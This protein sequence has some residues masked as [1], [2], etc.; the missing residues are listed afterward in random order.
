MADEVRIAV[1]M[2]CYNEEIT[3]S[4][5]IADFRAALPSANIY[6]YDNNST[7]RSIERA[8][9]V[10]AIVRRER[11]QGKGNV[12]KRMFADVEADAYVL[13]DGDDTYDAASAPGL[14]ACL[15]DQQLDMVNAARVTEAKGA[16]RSGHRLGNVLL[17][18]IVHMIFGDRIRD[19]LSGYRAF[20]RRFVKSFPA[21][22]TGFEIETELT[23]HALEL[24]MPTAEI[25]TPYRERP[26]GSTSKLRTFRD[27]LRILTTIAVLVKEERPLPFFSAVFGLL[28][29]TSLG[30][31]LP[32]F[33]EF[34]E[35]GLVPRFPTAILATGLML[36]GFLSFAC[37]LILDTVT[38]GRR[39]LKRLHYLSIPALAQT[40]GF[41]AV[42]DFPDVK[43]KIS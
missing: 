24:G 7:D 21:L 39:E 40:T 6:V 41:A 18:G 22:S 16:Y 35:T 34:L 37:G 42:E 38:H 20:S 13:V 33:V 5:V 26:K 43:R 27:G 12:I 4:K 30:L 32:I 19:V 14:I 36:L 1:L 17:S 25:D 29:L 10:G 9:E 31:A 3:I 2:P 15:L 8:Q 23:I 28:A 11:L